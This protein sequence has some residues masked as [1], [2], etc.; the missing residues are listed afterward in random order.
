MTSATNNETASSYQ[1]WLAKAKTYID[2]GFDELHRGGMGIEHAG[3]DFRKAA[4]AI[5]SA[6]IETAGFSRKDV[7]LW[8]SAKDGKM[9]G[10]IK[11]PAFND[12][13]KFAR[14]NSLISDDD[15]SKCE[16]IRPVGNAT[17]HASKRRFDDKTSKDAMHKAGRSA[18]DLLKR[19]EQGQPIMARQTANAARKQVYLGILKSALEAEDR[20]RSFISRNKSKLQRGLE[21]EFESLKKRIERDE[22]DL[23]AIDEFATEYFKKLQKEWPQEAIEEAQPILLGSLRGQLKRIEAKVSFISRKEKQIRSKRSFID[24]NEGY[25]DRTQD[26]EDARRELY[27][28]E[29]DV[30]DA[31]RELGDM[32]NGLQADFDNANRII[33]EEATGELRKRANTDAHNAGFS[34]DMFATKTEKAAIEAARIADEKA[35][36]AESAKQTKKTKVLAFILVA[37]ATCLM[38]YN[39][40]KTTPIHF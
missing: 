31:E 40:L 35:R 30:T 37:F 8:R 22:H 29:A 17:S 12:L 26:V 2:A 14:E 24:R 28:I 5:L 9:S 7:W 11:D 21:G 19:A 34:N 4:E 39:L 6:K 25:R 32:L 38:V 23:E 16:D 18:D 3:T 10:Q 33:G 36:A 13:E 15:Y 27:D 1:E 20:T